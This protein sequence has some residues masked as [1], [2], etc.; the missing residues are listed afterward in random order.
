MVVVV[1]GGSQSLQEARN[2][3]IFFLAN[4]RKDLK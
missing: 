4:R 3:V 2:F 1:S